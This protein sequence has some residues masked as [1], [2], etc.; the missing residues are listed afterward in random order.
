MNRTTSLLVAKLDESANEMNTTG[1]TTYFEELVKKAEYIKRSDVGRRR[2]IVLP[3][4]TPNGERI[5]IDT[6]IR[7][8][9]VLTGKGMNA[10][11]RFSTSAFLPIRTAEAINHYLI[12]FIEKVAAKLK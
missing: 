5:V 9:A 2:R 12:D 3:P 11:I 10:T 8:V 7:T 6:G 4:E 1:S